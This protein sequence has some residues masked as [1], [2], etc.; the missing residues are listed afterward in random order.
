MKAELQTYRLVLVIL[1]P[2][3]EVHLSP[4][5]FGP[6]RLHHSSLCCA[7]LTSLIFFNTTGVTQRYPEEL[8]SPI[9][10]IPPTS[11]DSAFKLSLKILYDDSGLGPDV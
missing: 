6:G 11:H 5:T 3:F 8:F 9:F 7:F 1:F 2:K 10:S 4:V